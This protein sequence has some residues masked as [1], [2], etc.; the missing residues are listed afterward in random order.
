MKMRKKNGDASFAI[1][2]LNASELAKARS[3]LENLAMSE[4]DFTADADPVTVKEKEIRVRLNAKSD[5]LTDLLSWVGKGR[6]RN[7]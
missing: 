1:Q 6:D 3:M 2:A 4:A 5:R 7:T